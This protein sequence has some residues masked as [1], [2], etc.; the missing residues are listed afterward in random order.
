MNYGDIKTHFKA[1]LNRSDITDALTE[2]FIDQG[3]A[4]IQRSLRV[5]LMER[6]NNYTITTQT[7]NVILPSDFLEIMDIYHNNTALARVP[8]KDMLERKR[9]PR[10]GTPEFFTR[11]ANELTIFPEPTDGTLTLNY[12]GE[13]DEMTA[14]TDE[15][16]LAAVASDLIIYAGLTYAADY[17]LDER[18]QLFEL[19][20][21]Q[22]I[23]EIQ[24]QANDQ[25]LSGTTQSI[26]PSANY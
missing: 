12:Y 7:G 9:N 5:P 20:Y 25:E 4:R 17:Y 23:N 2:T 15:N 8:L 22:F 19:K 14:D 6:Q 10:S 24:E 3:I 11:E 21:V 18:A 26:Q 16:N 1:L 13:F